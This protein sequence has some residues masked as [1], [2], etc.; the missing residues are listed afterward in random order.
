MPGDKP[1]GHP[2]HG[3][4]RSRRAGL[5]VVTVGYQDYDHENDYSDRTREHMIRVTRAAFAWYARHLR[6]AGYVAE[7]WMR[8]DNVQPGLF[9]TRK[10][11]V[12]GDHHRV[13]IGPARHSPGTPGT[14]A[15]RGTSPSRGCGTTTCSPACSSPG[16]QRFPVITIVFE[17]DEERAAIGRARN[18][19]ELAFDRQPVRVVPTVPDPVLPHGGM[20]GPPGGED[21]PG[22]DPEVVVL[23][24]VVGQAPGSAVIVVPAARSE[25]HTPAL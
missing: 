2:P 12:P 7:P 19:G 8:Y 10:S 17:Y 6:R 5:L 24:G 16:S 13:P 14:C 20:S 23:G 11:E 25:K 21:P 18:A 15:E 22:G 1:P 4:R 3:Y 9:I